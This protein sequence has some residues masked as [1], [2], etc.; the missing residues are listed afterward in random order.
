MHEFDPTSARPRF[1]RAMAAVALCAAAA[2]QLAACAD[3]E[4]TPG[5]PGG[6]GG[7]S[8]CAAGL[9]ACDGTCVDLETDA[10]HCG[11]CDAACEIGPCQA[12]ACVTGCAA[13][14]SDCDGTCVDLSVDATHCGDCDV[15]CAAPDTCVDGTCACDET[16]ADCGPGCRSDLDCDDDEQ[17]EGGRCQPLCGPGEVYCD[18]TCIDGTSDDQNCGACDFACATGESCEASSCECGPGVCGSCGVTDLGGASPQTVSG[19]SAGGVDALEPSCSPGST[20]EVVYSFTPDETA[21][22]TFTVDAGHDTTLYLLDDAC[23]ETHCSEVGGGGANPELTANLEAGVTIYVVVDGYQDEGPFTLSVSDAPLVPCPG[24]VLGNAPQMVT[25][26]NTGEADLFMG[27]CTFLP[28]GP[29]ATFSFTAQTTGPHLVDA[30]G[31]A[32][33]VVLYVLDGNCGG[34]ELGCSSDFLA[35]KVL[36]DL[37]AGQEVTIVVDG[38]GPTG[39][40]AYSLQVTEVDCPAATIGALPATLTDDFANYTDVFTPSC[41]FFSGADV[42]YGFTAPTADTYVFDTFGSS[43]DTDLYALAGSCNGPE[44]ECNTE[45]AGNAAQVVVDLA[46]GETVVVGVDGFGPGAFTLNARKVICPDQVFGFPPQ[47]L[48][49]TTT[50]GVHQYEPLC[51]AAGGPEVTHFFTAP[52]AGEYTFDTTGSSIDTK[53]YV[54]DGG[55]SGAELGC[56][57]VF[58]GTEQLTVQLGAFQ[59]V[60]VFVDSA[61]LTAGDYVLSVSG[62]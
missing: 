27:S 55:C 34:V 9:T 7:G 5:D 1:R 39:V 28:G 42:L 22:Y 30:S 40:G 14:L 26:D 16:V 29:D 4:S 11:D 46:A 33:P 6:A 23:S 53:L 48:T 57:D 36:V 47:T 60:I 12:G 45:L 2:W 17:C 25:G 59:E 52:A 13:G 38:A 8:T 3:G 58:G 10:A 32:F 35:P 56:A 43:V 19:T 20:R 44:L 31:S 21:T 61:G 37:T 51:A 54:R 49:G 41:L 15:A 24:A 18:Q 50:Q 62:P